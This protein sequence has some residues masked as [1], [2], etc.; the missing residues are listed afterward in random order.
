MVYVRMYV[1]TNVH[2]DKGK[3]IRPSRD[4][5]KKNTV[6]LMQL[7]KHV[8]LFCSIKVYGRF[9]RIKGF[10]MFLFLKRL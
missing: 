10:C 2:T 9:Y 3:T 1:G 4:G 8:L 6:T 7:M 5:G